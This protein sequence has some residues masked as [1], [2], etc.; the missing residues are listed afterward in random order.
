[1]VMD[2][3]VDEQAAA[4]SGGWPREVALVAAG[5]GELETIRIGRM[6]VTSDGRVD[7]EIG[8]DG[9]RWDTWFVE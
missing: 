1:M 9:D 3:K 5:G 7:G 8:G 4:V 2:G 6:E